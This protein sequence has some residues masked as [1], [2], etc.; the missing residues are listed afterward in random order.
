LAACFASK[1]VED[2]ELDDLCQE[3][4]NLAAGHLYDILIIHVQR[5]G[6]WVDFKAK[7]KRVLSEIK[8]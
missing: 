3:G 8:N 6:F 5:S 1:A 4:A 2:N 7:Q